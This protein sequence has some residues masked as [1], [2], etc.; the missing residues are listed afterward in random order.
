M[1]HRLLIISIICLTSILGSQCREIVLRPVEY[2]TL[3]INLSDINQYIPD[4]ASLYHIYNRYLSSDRVKSHSI[5]EKAERKFFLRKYHKESSHI[6]DPIDWWQVDEICQGLLPELRKKYSPKARNQKIK[7]QSGEI[8][9]I[10]SLKVR[11]DILSSLLLE[12]ELKKW[13]VQKLKLNELAKHYKIQNSHQEQNPVFINYAQRT[14]ETLLNKVEGESN[15]LE[16]ENQKS[17]NAVQPTENSGIAVDQPNSFSEGTSKGGDAGYN[18]G[19][20]KKLKPKKKSGRRGQKVS[21]EDYVKK[22][23]E[24]SNWCQR[25]RLGLETV[26]EFIRH[27]DPL[28]EWL[29]DDPLRFK[30]YQGLVRKRDNEKSQNF[31]SLPPMVENSND[32]ARIQANKGSFGYK[33]IPP[34]TEDLLHVIDSISTTE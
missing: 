7:Y 9:D 10:E 33:T 24:E 18:V 1:H 20:D 16:S 5:L 2:E 12:P 6:R 19:S 8:I 29:G 31:N 4:T 17:D 25:G 23:Q 34:L 26:R 22:C 3:T 21:P 27:K 14:V 13:V 11:K 30:Y 32:V 28:S 15:R